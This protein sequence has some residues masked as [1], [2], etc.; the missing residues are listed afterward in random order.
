MIE[1]IILRLGND[2]EFHLSEK[3]CGRDMNSKQILLYAAAKCAAMTLWMIMR[4][5]QFQP[6]NLEIALTGELSTPT[7]ESK[8][9]FTAF[10]IVYNVECALDEEQSKIGEWVHQTQNTEC[11]VMIMLQKIAPVNLQTAIVATGIDCKA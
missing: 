4:K 8:S 1:K 6:K 5:E 11:G 7:L 10:H 9:V 3:Q 2:G